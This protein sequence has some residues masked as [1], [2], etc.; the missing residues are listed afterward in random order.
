MG[1]GAAPVGNSNIAQCSTSQ[2]SWGT[3]NGAHLVLSLLPQ[4]LLREQQC[5]RRALEGRTALPAREAEQ[6]GK[7]E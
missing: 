1:R 3:G 7:G 6:I 5:S 4:C 2:M